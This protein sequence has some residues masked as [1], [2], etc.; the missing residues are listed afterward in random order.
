MRDIEVDFLGEV[1][2]EGIKGVGKHTFNKV[3]TLRETFED[4][5][6][7]TKEELIELGIKEEI[8]INIFEKINE[9]D[10]K[11]TVEVLFTEYIIKDFLNK[12]YEKI[13]ELD[14]NDLDINIFLIKALAF[15]K[16]EEVIEFYI[17]QRITRSVVT[18][19]GICLE[20]IC[21]FSGAK[22]IPENENVE[23]Q[24]E[25]F[26]IK[27]SYD[28]IDYY[29]Q[30]KSGPN[31]MNVQMVKAL[32]RMIEKI[33]QK[34]DN[35][36]AILGMTYGKNSAISGQIKK[37]LE[38][39]DDRAYIGKEFWNLISGKENFYSELFEIIDKLS[40]EV[41]DYTFFEL[42]EKKKKDLEEEWRDKYGNLGEKGFKEFINT[43]LE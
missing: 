39:F 22:K 15:S 6:T 20:K 18:S 14:L 1:I 19:W 11:K 24:G 3:T 41:K 26:D 21:V 8:A 30:L 31:T 25:K 33:E 17:H 2:K 12:S 40:Y 4:F 13:N 29:I 35:V 10:F 32:N 38:D 27:K 5:S 9:L 16:A 7:I 43:Y 36:K 42:V 23:D 37:Y 28:D 34:N